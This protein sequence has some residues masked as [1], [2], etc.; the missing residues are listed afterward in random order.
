MRGVC[1]ALLMF[2]AACADPPLQ[3]DDAGA[4]EAGADDTGPV[5]VR[6]ARAADVRVDAP[7]DALAGDLAFDGAMPDRVVADLALPDARVDPPDPDAAPPRAPCDPIPGVAYGQLSREGPVS[8]R[9]PPEHGDLNLALRGWTPTVGA[10][11]LVDINGPTDGRAPKLNTMFTDDRVPTFVENFR[12]HQWDW[13]C[14]CRAGPIED[15]PVTL[16]AFG[17][18][19]GEVV[20]VPD[21]DYRIG[22]D[23]QVLVLYLDDDSVTLKYTREDNVVVGYTV[24]VSGVCVEPSLRALYTRLDAAGRNDL[25]ALRG[26]EPFARARGA[27]IR[28]AIRDTGAYL[29]PR[30]R[31]DWW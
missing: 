18:R 7:A 4:A 30:S 14:N 10:L 24:Q 8:D 26:H 12:V 31:K 15:P 1:C 2:A 5:D 3:P 9:P 27:S 29:D 19:P 16:T 21:S 23:F 28:V 25:P 11:G 13:G 22:D 17:T 6:D 20:E